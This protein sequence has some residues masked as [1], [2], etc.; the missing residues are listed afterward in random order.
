MRMFETRHLPERYDD[1]APDGSEIR[2]L[3]GMTSGG[4]CHCTLPV[5]RTSRP[6][7]HRTVEEIWYFM[8]GQGQV[9]R[10]QDKQEQVL[11]VQPGMCVTIPTGTHFQ[12]RNI[13][14]APLEFIIVTMPPWPGE[15]EAAKLDEGHWPFTTHE[16]HSEA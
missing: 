10:K 15:G 11:D 13:G 6:V 4:M 12:F 16:R 3:A 5:G 8:G 9:W 1:I 7:Y 2:L 14:Q